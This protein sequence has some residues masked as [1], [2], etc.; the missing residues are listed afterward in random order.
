[1]LIF[2]QEEM[3]RYLVGKLR[4]GQG[5]LHKN[6]AGKPAAASGFKISPVISLW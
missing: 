1:M 4:P 3:N 6:K 5:Y 2:C